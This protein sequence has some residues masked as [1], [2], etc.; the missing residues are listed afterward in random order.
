ME[1]QSDV[2]HQNSLQ[3]TK[4][5]L[6]IAVEKKSHETADTMALYESAAD[7]PAVFGDRTTP[8]YD[9]ERE[10]VV[11]ALPH[12]MNTIAHARDLRA[13]TMLMHPRSR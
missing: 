4:L 2:M 7:R 11:G 3:Q 5:E 9:R 10:V 12:A 6:R 1:P 13:D 8:N